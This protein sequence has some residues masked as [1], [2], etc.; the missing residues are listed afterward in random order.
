[1]HSF[2]TGEIVIA[3]VVLAWVV[4]RQ[5]QARPL[6]PRTMFGVPA[7]LTVLGLLALAHDARASHGLTP[8][9][10]AWIAADLALSVV[11]GAVRAPVIRLFERDGRLWRQ[12]G[13][14]TIVL[15]LVSIGLRIGIGV[16]AAGAGAGGEDTLLLSFGISLAAQYAVLALRARRFRIPEAG[17][18]V[19][20]P[21]QAGFAASH[22]LAATGG[23]LARAGRWS[24]RHPWWLIAAWLLVLAAATFGHKAL[25]GTYSDEFT[26]PGSPA[27]QGAAVLKAHN[28]GSGGQS[29]QLVFAVSR[30]SLAQDKSA[31]ENS[32]AQFRK[33]PD[34]L[35]ASDPLSAD[36]T[37][38]NGQTA[39]S[40]V[41]FSVDPATLGTSYITGV[42]NATAGARSAGVAVSYGGQLGQADQPKAS[43]L[44]SEAIGI[45]AAILVLLLGFGSVYAAG[46][47]LVTAILGAVAGIG[48]LGMAA[49]A[50]TFASVSPTLGVMMGLGVG[51][52]YALFLTTRHRQLVMDGADPDEAA[53]TAIASSG[54]SVLIAAATVIIAVL[55]LYASGIAFIGKLGLA[56]AITVAVAAAC[57]V[58]LVPALL[59]LAGRNIDRRRVRRPVAESAGGS[60]FWPRY[61][62]R[63]AAHPWLALGG[64]VAVLLI[65][66]APVL[67]LQL[68]HVDAGA[69][70]DSYSSKQAY[71]AIGSAFGPGANGP[72]TVVA[73]LDKA[74]TSSPAQLSALESSLHAALAKVP[75]VAS[76]SAV[77]ASPDGDVLSATVIPASS[78]Q[79]AATRTLADTLQ[80]TT[81]PAVLNPAGAQGYVTGSLAGQLDFTSDVSQRL[82]LIIGVVIAAAFLLLLASFRS[83]VL[84]LKAAILNFFSISAAIGVIVAVFQ[85]GWG[86]SLLG[87]SE[88]VPIESYV[89]M[90]MFAIVFGLSMD[91]EVFLLTR[92]REA[93][94]R[95][96]DN[97]VSVAE[98]LSATARVISCAA[99]II[100]C[101][102]LAFLLSTSVVVKMLALGLGVSIIAD[103]TLIRL[104]VVPA[105]MFLLGRANWW[106]PR[107]LTR[108]PNLLEPV[109]FAGQA[110]TAGDPRESQGTA[111]SE[112][113]P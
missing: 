94:G 87:V 35:S 46:L 39:Y 18:P 86:S 7:V 50:T 100:T 5:V 65:L 45:A 71:D 29:G 8:A 3:A 56:A 105:T 72:L 112:A 61:A 41:H 70:P 111:P 47:P 25:G 1:M 26:L 95:T 33:L 37:S 90:I 101:V 91:Y 2:G 110:A 44:R 16:L 51:I 62:R 21:A 97:A 4:V 68:G 76:V 15:W 17:P 108:L 104:L 36:T 98:G 32:V 96:R 31:V 20:E 99:L 52:D 28:P 103:A 27:A 11:T 107:W 24:A 10:G 113:L 60:D 9:D 63:I 67:S 77:H 30:G 48:V 75:D 64:G 81:L 14:L 79:D 89:P 38:K 82:P 74:K 84:A 19:A 106:T 66:S 22:A 102:F 6:V 23:R 59:G 54:R 85:W 83:P 42:N 40:T 12:G 13:P 93:W 55:G 58:T 53:G 57:A 49:S 43:D 80:D 73:Q 92:I 88:K 109:D 69:S 78:P 34:V